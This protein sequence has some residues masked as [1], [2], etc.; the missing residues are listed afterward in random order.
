MKTIVKDFKGFLQEY[1]VIGLAVAFVMGVAT[2]ELVKSISDNL[3]MPLADPFVAGTWKT[4]TLSLGP[5][6]FGWGPVLA[7]AINFVLLAFIVFIVVD[8]VIKQEKKDASV[9]AKKK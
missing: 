1:K 8:K 7:A 6:V 3:I 4:A 9:A 2:N 5:F